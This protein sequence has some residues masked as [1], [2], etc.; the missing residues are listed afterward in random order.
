MFGLWG[1]GNLPE[2]EKRRRT[3]LRLLSFN[4]IFL[5]WAFY[6]L[7]RYKMDAEGDAAITVREFAKY[8]IQGIGIGLLAITAPKLF[9]KFLDLIARLRFGAG[10]GLQDTTTQTI[11]TETKT[12]QPLPLVAQPVVPPAAPVEIVKEKE[13]VE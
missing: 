6:Y 10:N 5:H 9:E 7:L 12:T 11:V 13:P 8:I 4:I 1:G 3:A 2:D